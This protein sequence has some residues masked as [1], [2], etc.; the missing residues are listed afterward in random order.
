MLDRIN[1]AVLIVLTVCSV[2]GLL[3]RTT[4]YRKIPV[5]HGDAYGLGDVIDLIFLAIVV[6]LLGVIFLLSLLMVCVRQYSQAIRKL[7]LGILITLLYY[8]MHSRLY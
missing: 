4:I 5:G 7:L 1:R 3:Y 8:L 2:S 6:S